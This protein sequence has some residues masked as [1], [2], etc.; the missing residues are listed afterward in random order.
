[1][2]DYQFFKNVSTFQ[3]LGWYHHNIVVMYNHQ[4]SLN[5]YKVNIN[6]RTEIRIFFCVNLSYVDFVGYVNNNSN[7]KNKK[8]IILK[9]II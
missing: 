2:L 8:I 6:L 1:M 5:Y 7:K 9:R 4:L 3:L